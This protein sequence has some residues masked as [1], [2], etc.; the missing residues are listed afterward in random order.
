MPDNPTL[1]LE[2]KSADPILPEAEICKQVNRRFLLQQAIVTQAAHELS[3]ST[4]YYYTPRVLGYSIPDQILRLERLQ[5]LVPLRERLADDRVLYWVLSRVA[6]AMAF[7]HTHLQIPANQRVPV[8]AGWMMGEM[9]PVTVHG[10]FNLINITWQSSSDRLVVLDWSSAPALGF[11]ANEGPRELDIAH[12]L[13]CLLLQQIPF[14][15]AMGRYTALRDF[16]LKEYQTSSPVPIHHKRLARMMCR[17]NRT[18]LFNQF[19]QG[20]VRSLAHSLIGQCRFERDRLR[21]P[22]SI[23]QDQP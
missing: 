10:D 9:Y 6:R 3:L 13:R 19:R 4:D 8:S 11:V 5:G 20:M 17:L 14:G 21:P 16:F 1:L 12:F 22:S 18:I 7:I 23:S 15:K 2:M